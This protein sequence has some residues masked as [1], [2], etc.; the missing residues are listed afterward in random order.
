M[1]VRSLSQNTVPLIL[2]V[3]LNGR[4]TTVDLDK[5]GLIYMGQRKETGPMEVEDLITGETYIHPG[6][7]LVLNSGFNIDGVRVHGS[8]LGRSLILS[9]IH[10]FSGVK[11]I[12]ID[13]VYEKEGNEEKKVVLQLLSESS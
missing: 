8:S 4:Q 6:T 1:E 13:S 9:A 3:P 10:P 7:T 2:R 5:E 12:E 11:E